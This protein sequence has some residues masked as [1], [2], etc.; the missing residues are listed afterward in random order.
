MLPSSKNSIARNVIHRIPLQ[1]IL[2]VPFVLQI[3][4][5]VGIVGYLS[6]KNGQRAVNDLA[7]QLETEVGVKIKQNVEI[8]LDTAQNSHDVFAASIESGIDSRQLPIVLP[9]KLSK[10]MALFPK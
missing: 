9:F 1:A 10:N 7:T 6:Y 3:F 5:T 4:A 8:F 2:I